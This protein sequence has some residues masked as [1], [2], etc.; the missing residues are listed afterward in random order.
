MK[1]SHKSD[2]VPERESFLAVSVLL[3][4]QKYC[5]TCRD[6][7]QF[8]RSFCDMLFLKTGKMSYHGHTVGVCAFTIT[9]LETVF[10]LDGAY[11]PHS[12]AN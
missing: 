6:Q 10:T 8:F 12:K 5:D 2:I 1:E 9:S 11:L 4:D 7:R 3:A